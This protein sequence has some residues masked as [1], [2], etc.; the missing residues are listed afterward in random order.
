MGRGKFGYARPVTSGYKRVRSFPGIEALRPA[1]RVMRRATYTGGGR[2]VPDL[3]V[4]KTE[5]MGQVYVTSSGAFANGV[6]VCP[7]IPAVAN[8]P[9]INVRLPWLSQTSKLYDFYR[10]RKFDITYHPLMQS[11]SSTTGIVGQCFMAFDYDVFDGPTQDPTAIK[12]TEGSIT[13]SPTEKTTIRMDCNQATNGQPWQRFV[14]TPGIAATLP[15]SQAYQSLFLFGCVG[16]PAGGAVFGQLECSYEIEYWNS[17]TLALG[18]SGFGVDS[19]EQVSH[20]Q[21]FPLNT[22]TLAAP[23][24]TAADGSA[25]KTVLPLAGANVANGP[26]A[27]SALWA[28]NTADVNKGFSLYYS[29]NGPQ[30]NAR[31]FLVVVNANGTGLASVNLSTS[32]TGNSGVLID[33]QSGQFAFNATYRGGGQVGFAKSDGVFCVLEFFITMQPQGKSTYGLAGSNQVMILNPS[34]TTLT[35]YDVQIIEVSLNQT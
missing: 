26:S 14:T 19:V 16:V 3:V 33:N 23:F 2:G 28:L 30:S 4:K 15:I 22:G 31:R 12:D 6:Y 20:F 18:T 17:T 5:Q 27:S 10:F 32:G 11:V 25:G 24:G 8:Q 7:S 1:K 34:G 21:T 29:P 13:F 9:L 35:N